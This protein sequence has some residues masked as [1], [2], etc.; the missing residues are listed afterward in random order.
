MSNKNVKENI[1]FPDFELDNFTKAI[2]N[3]HKNI[4][5]YDL[6]KGNIDDNYSFISKCINKL[7]RTR[8]EID[9]IIHELE[10]ILLLKLENTLSSLKR[11]SASRE[12]T[13]ISIEI[14]NFNSNN[15]TEIKYKTLPPSLKNDI[16]AQIILYTN[17]N[18]IK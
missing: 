13:N 6:T 4:Q 3:F 18:L 8:K 5:I 14:D 1:I 11:P 17:F 10:S 2:Q 15:S 9:S 12:N 16:F 7:I